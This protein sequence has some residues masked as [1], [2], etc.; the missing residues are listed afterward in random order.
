MGKKKRN[1]VSLELRFL[2]I[3]Q[4]DCEDW[5]APVRGHLFVSEADTLGRTRFVSP[6]LHKPRRWKFDFAWPEHWLA[7]EMEGGAFSGGRHTR[8]VGY[9]GDCQKYSAA[10]VLGWRLL[11]YTILDVIDR[12]KEML[13][14]IQSVLKPPNPRS[15]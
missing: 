12:P 6:K 2:S 15:A 7:V 5:P 11:R 9:A 14:E 13:A 10:V 4:H 8:G 3:W 1:S